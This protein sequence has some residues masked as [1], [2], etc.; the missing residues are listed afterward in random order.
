MGEIHRATD[1]TLGRTVA[2]KVLSEPRGRDPEVRERFTREAL[3]AARLSAH[4]NVVT[5]FD[6]G[7]YGGRPYIVMEYLEGGSLHDRLSAGEIPLRLALAWLD[8]AAAAIDSA[9]KV[10]IVHRDIKPANLLLDA[11]DRLQVTDFGIAAATGFDT[12]TEP[13]SV[14][15]TAGYLAPEQ[16][17]GEPATA[18]SDRY[19]LAVVAYELLTGRRPFASETPVTEAFAHVTS[20]VPS[21][22]TLRPD[23]PASLDEVFGRALAKDPAARPRTAHQLVEDLRGCFDDDAPTTVALP[24]SAARR[25]SGARPLAIG[26]VLALVLALAGAATAALLGSAAGPDAQERTVTAIRTFV[27]TQQGSTETMTVTE[28]DPSPPPTTFDGT[29][30]NDQGFALIREGDYERA[31]PLL[32][33]AVQALAGTGS[34]AE[35]YASYNLALARLTLGRCDG[36]LD[37]LERSEAVQGHRGEIRKLRRQAERACSPGHGKDDKDD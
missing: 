35:A 19:A 2:V 29:A 27:T 28:A 36:V 37:L 15:G 17:R 25:A 9:H 21:V 7:E 26:V 24:P 20:P 13:G 22:R 30:L 12:L 14:L 34:L 4:P 6:V 16:A 23:L 10:G 31:V 11:D 32:E 33:R 5:L 18:A 1:E 3:A 8:D